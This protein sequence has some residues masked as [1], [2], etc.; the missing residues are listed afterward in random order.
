VFGLRFD[1]H[2]DFD[3]RYGGTPLYGEAYGLALEYVDPRW[4]V[5][6]TG[7][8]HDPLFPDSVERGNGAA[9]YAETRV[10][11]TTAFGV[12]GKLDVTP[13]GRKTYG[14]VTA[15]H[16]FVKQ[17]VL[18][19]AELEIVHQKVDLGGTNNQFV[20]YVLGSY[21]LGPF[22][23]DLGLG[24]YSPDLRLRL[25]DQ[26]VADLN[27]HWFT[28]SHLEL[29]LTNRLQNY[30]FGAGGTGSGYS[31]LMLHYRL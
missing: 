6:A 31:L 2:P 22:M 18:V 12:E 30:D 26:E 11:K 16:Y 4:E 23:I 1:E 25:I 13:D 8:I 19:E 24:Q 21:Y 29:M 28:T 27:I 20:A 7:F 14:G 17:K 3:R 10:T 9:L 5:H 15:K